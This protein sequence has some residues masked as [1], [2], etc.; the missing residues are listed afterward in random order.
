[1]FPNKPEQV[2]EFRTYTAS[3]GNLE[4]LNDRF[5]DHTV[6][7]F[8]KHGMTNVGYWTPA[9][10]EP[11]A[12]DTLIY[13]LAHKTSE[14]AKASWDGFRGDPAWAAAKKASE[15]QA[16]GPLTIPNGVKSQYLKATDVFAD[17]V[18][19]IGGPRHMRNPK[20]PLDLSRCGFNYARLGSNQQP[21]VP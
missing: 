7:L 12:A 2:F 15:D 10:N 8:E 20:K 18:K 11:G 21:S 14:T 9:K 17:E 5:R 19:A 6:K 3:P 4:R 16:H 1:M 13:L